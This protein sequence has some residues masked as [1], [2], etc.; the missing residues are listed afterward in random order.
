MTDYFEVSSRDGAARSG[1]L[2]LSDPVPTPTLA[3]DILVDAG[4]QW[5]ED[6]SI[7]EGD[8]SA[9]TILPHRGF[10]GGTA[11]E[12]KDAFA[13]DY[14]D[15]DFPSAAVVTPDTAAGHSVDAYLLAGAPSVVGYASAFVE[16]IIDTREA[17]P[18]DTALGLSG[19][20]TPANLA[21]LVYAGVDLLDTHRAAVRG[22]QGWYLTTD[23][24][25]RLEAL[26]ERASALPCACSACQQPVESFTR[27]DCVEHNTNLLEAELARVRG[28]V[29]NGTLRSYLEGQSRHSTWQTAAVRRLDQQ[30]GYLEQR[31][32]VVR[33]RSFSATTEDALR[34]VEVQRFA[35]R[36][37]SRVQHRFEGKPLLLV[38]CS[39]RKPYGESRSHSQFQDAANYRAPLASLTSPLGVVPRELELTYPAQHYDAAV[40]GHWSDSEI[41]FVSSVLERYL[42]EG[43]YSRVIAH[44]AEDGY[45]AVVETA[46]SGHDLDVEFTVEGHPTDEDSLAAL[47]ETLAGEPRIT[48]T[49][50]EHATV[51]AIADYQFGAGAGEKLF[52]DFSLSGRYPKNRLHDSEGEQ[53]A[54]MVPQY[55]MLALTLAGAE[56]WLESDIPVRRVEIDSFVPS[57]SV[58]APGVVD[59]DA[60]IRPGEEV[61][62][63]GPRAF[64]V[65]RAE[66]SGPE[67]LES[68]RGIGVDVRHAERR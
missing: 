68:T 30:W 23:G 59:A 33:N 41:S 44:V 67:L 19:V 49:D 58:L 63:E 43:A 39:A 46:C 38:P 27:E 54:T 64:A 45:Q 48:V 3:D 28:H 21:L 65:G 31:T 24:E 51:K 42:E 60:S 11:S 50:Q 16:A 17:I 37:C 7:P 14:P 1:E 22:T 25:Q 66:M 15:V 13:V 18:D 52:G 40:T 2:R 55:G 62:V 4:S 61:I 35:D 6:H 32:P 26:E 12:V 20:A 57:G 9:L 8:E 29:R 5:T 36:L 34:R 47:A 10:P 56:Q 53:L